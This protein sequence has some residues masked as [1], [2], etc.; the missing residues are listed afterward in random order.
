MFYAPRHP[1]IHVP[2]QEFAVHLST[3]QFTFRPALLSACVAAL[4]LLSGCGATPATSSPD[5][6]TIPLTGSLHGGQQAVQG[7]HIYLYAA[8]TTGYGAASASLLTPGIP[9]T[10]T[11]LAGNAY[12]TSDASG[13]FSYGGLYTG[14]T[15]GT[16]I[17]LLAL[18]GNPTGHPGGTP[19]P[20]IA[21]SAAIGDCAGLTSSTY[22]EINEVTTVGM[23]F[24]LSGFM[25]DPTHVGTRS[26]NIAGLKT[27]FATAN[28]LVDTTTG[29]ALTTTPEGNGTAPQ[30]YVNTLANIIS[31][32]VNSAPA[33][34]SP[35]DQLF[36]YTTVTTAPAPQN[37]LSA[38][39][40]IA[41]F[42]AAQVANLYPLAA[43][44]APFQPGVAPQPNDFA[45]GITYTA[46]SVAA[47]QPGTVVI[48]SAGNIWTS[49]CQSCLTPTAPD[50]L[51][52]FS[53]TG[54]L[55]NSYIGSSTPTTQVLH[56]IKGIAIDASGA[57]IYTVN[58]GI[59]GGPTPGTGDDQIVKMDTAAGTV[60]S[61]FPLDFD[62]ATYG[63]DTFNGIAVDNSGEL[64]ATALNT[65]AVIEATP[66][67]NLINGSP[68]FVGGTLG[69]A[70][71]NIGNIW[72]AG[73]GGNNIIEFDTNGDFLQNFTPSGLNQPLGIAIND[74]NEIWTIDNGSAALSKIEFYN[75][76]NGSGSPYTNLGL[77]QA[78]ITAI[79]GASQVLI[80]NCRVSCP[81]SG[82]TLPDSLLRLSESG[83]P[84]TGVSGAN[85]GVQ[86]P[87][88]SGVG[89][90]AVDA[91]GNV[92]VAD[93]V[94]GKL[95]EVI[96]FATPTIQPIAAA[97]SNGALG[98]E[99]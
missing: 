32:C 12:V 2:P 98:Q 10:S 64:W 40:N 19:N 72:F 99:P 16:Q 11:D 8:S 34:N 83:V 5:T 17:Y 92:W 25:T 9:G 47:V 73:T 74:A 95:T 52:E 86:V 75:G 71:D 29:L 1:K 49:N 36:A 81:S 33:T 21:L 50:S 54:T 23:A 80:P 35:C 70:T 53:P 85:S 26:S 42:P 27:A 60:Q 37:T 14:C 94:T 68:F 78:A 24:A 38:L 7:S 28:N 48:D 46:T 44:F 45:L 57:N 59:A 65:G 88:F 51:L 56:G 4:L 18:G 84:N 96:G 20:A 39:L 90:A 30:Q 89:G 77:A 76:N 93:S 3:P 97:S 22:T 58:Q 66:G 79:D 67:G 13:A 15:D 82:S 41:A 61:G 63:V 55:L 6:R 31:Y 69:V 62:Q 87:G 91:S 43:S